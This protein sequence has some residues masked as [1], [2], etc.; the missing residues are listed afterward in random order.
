MTL[1]GL[2]FSNTYGYSASVIRRE[3]QEA[4]EVSSPWAVD[5]PP[6]VATAATA[7]GQLLLLLLLLHEL[8]HY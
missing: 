8:C 3:N 4:H 7:V 5:P 1:K 2:P 6:I